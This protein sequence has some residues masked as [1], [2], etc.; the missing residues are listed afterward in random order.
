MSL[1]K[2]RGA[3]LAVGLVFVGMTWVAHAFVVDA[4]SYALEGAEKY[5]SKKGGYTLRKDFW[6]GNA[7][8]GEAQ[9]VKH[10]LIAGNS[11]WFWIGTDA[12]DVALAVA[13]YDK[14]GKTT[15]KTDGEPYLQ[16]VKKGKRWIGARVEVSKTGTYLIAFKITTKDQSEAP[17]AVAYAYK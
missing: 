15:P 5:V 13:V 8:S 11:Y 16:E 10:Q 12:D 17:W 3:W 6:Q 4:L 7:P 2:E 9:A 1:S 14:K